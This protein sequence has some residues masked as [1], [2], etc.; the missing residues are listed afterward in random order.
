MTHHKLKVRTEI[1]FNYKATDSSTVEDE[2]TLKE[3]R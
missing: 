2:E 3:T 1:P